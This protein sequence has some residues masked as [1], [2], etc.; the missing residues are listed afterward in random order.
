[1]EKV[2]TKLSDY[3]S[4]PIVDMPLNRIASIIVQD[5]KKTSKNG[6]NY[7]A[8]PYLSAMMTLDTIESNY[9]ADSGREI[10]MYFLSNATTWKGPVAKEIKAHLNTLLKK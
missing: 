8:K 1:M 9:I 5:W 3:T 7:A 6:V 10:V 4:Q 2:V